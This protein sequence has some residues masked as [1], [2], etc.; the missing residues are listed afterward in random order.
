[1]TKKGLRQVGH[2]CDLVK[3]MDRIFI[4]IVVDDKRKAPARS[5]CGPIKG[6]LLAVVDLRELAARPAEY[7]RR[8]CPGR[9]PVVTRSL[10]VELDTSELL[11]SGGVSPLLSMRKKFESCGR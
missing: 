8:G 6:S 7:R 9:P 2:G 11:L 1:M 4:A 10:E 3:L 5:C